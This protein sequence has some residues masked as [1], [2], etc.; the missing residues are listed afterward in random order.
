MDVRLSDT[1]DLLEQ[2]HRGRKPRYRPTCG[3]KTFATAARC[4]RPFDEVP[5]FLQPQSR[6]KQGLSWKQRREIYRE[7]CTHLLEMMAAA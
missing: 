1:R 4:C 7:R 2:D 6:R 3:L 5:A